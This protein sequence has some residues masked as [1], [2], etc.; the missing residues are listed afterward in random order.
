M[1]V[2]DH[3]LRGERQDETHEILVATVEKVHPRIAQPYD[4]S[5]PHSAIFASSVARYVFKK[6]R[7]TVRPK[8]VL[9]SAD[10]LPPRSTNLPPGQSSSV[11][12]ATGGDVVNRRSTAPA[13]D[14]ADEEILG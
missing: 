14:E 10:L 8:F 5:T 12:S 2:L 11:D 1:T 3:S 6:G 7:T 9:A 4:G 13:A